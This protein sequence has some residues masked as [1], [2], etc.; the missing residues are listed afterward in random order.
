M[1]IKWKHEKYHC[2]T[3]QEFSELDMITLI[4]RKKLTVAYDNVRFLKKRFVGLNAR[5]RISEEELDF[6][7][8]ILTNM[9]RLYF[10]S[11]VEGFTRKFCYKIAFIRD[12][13]TKTQ[14]NANYFNFFAIIHRIIRD[15]FQ[16]NLP[17][18]FGQWDI[19]DEL[20]FERNQSAHLGKHHTFNQK[21]L[22]IYYTAILDYFAFIES[23]VFRR[24]KY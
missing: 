23:E 2:W 15:K 19:I 12:G 13:I 1:S 4:F 5:D 18:D 11:T 22:G 9:A 24:L 10:Y 21:G 7:L 8:G 16:I 3:E 20:R 14:F 6:K 17:T